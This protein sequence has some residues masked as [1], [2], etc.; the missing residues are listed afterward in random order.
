MSAAD[1]EQLARDPDWQVR[2]AVAERE[3]LPPGLLWQLA[4][5]ENLWVRQ[6]IA[7]HPH[8]PPELVAR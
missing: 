8:L 6:A 3:D 5:D 7:G 1:V 4:E 2:Q